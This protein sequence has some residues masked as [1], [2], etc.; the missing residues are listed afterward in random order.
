M[1]VQPAPAH[2]GKLCREVDLQLRPVGPDERPRAGVLTGVQELLPLARRELALGGPD[3]VTYRHA[4]QLLAPPAEQREG[5]IVH[6][7]DLPLIVE[8]DDR[9][10]RSLEHQPKQAFP[11]HPLV[12]CMH[13]NERYTSCEPLWCY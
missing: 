8:Q 1:H 5:G 3:A 2:D 11:P 13:R 6:L 7:N 9:V 4:E 10:G 12:R